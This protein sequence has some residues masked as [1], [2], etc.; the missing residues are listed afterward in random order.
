VAQEPILAAGLD[1]GSAWTRV[2]VCV[3][4]GECLRYAAHAMA[5]ARG[6][7]RGLI[8][9]QSAVA[10]SIREAMHL[11]ETI[12]G[13]PIGSV[14]VG[15]GGPS[16][17]G[18]QARGIYEFGHRR[19]V[20]QSDLRYALHLAARPADDEE[21]ILLHVLPQ[22]FTVDG[23]PPIPH[24]FGLECLRLEAHALLITTSRQEHQALV[25][26]VHQ[27][28]LKVEETVFEALGAAYACILAEDRAGGVAL[29]DI[30]A[31]STNAVYYDGDSM[32]YAIGM[33]VSGDHFTRD[34]GELKSLS[35]EEAERLKLAHGCA[36]PGLTA[37][38]IVIELPADLGRPAREIH[39][40]EL[41]EI[42]E[43]RANQLFGYIEKGRQ[44]HARGMPLREGVV[45][46]GGGARLEG[47]VQV[48]EKVLDCS[49]RLGF[50]RGIEKWPPKAKRPCWTVAAGLAMYSARLQLRRDKPS[51]GPGF[52]SLFTGRS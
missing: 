22:D 49:A 17:R 46:T 20:E 18:V 36:L 48:A 52:W 25:S 4:E 31:H 23:R 16:I 15:V 8:T 26:S 41:I 3:V 42:L 51:G 29:V 47:M 7:H 12:A 9:D 30:G 19:P 37:D 34:V 27:A 2:A 1:A 43:A 28:S 6:W 50:P 14:V 39:R 32:L 5:P 38:N 45:L 35:F 10:A 40:R 24:P 33:P 21:R 11:A 13:R 44:V